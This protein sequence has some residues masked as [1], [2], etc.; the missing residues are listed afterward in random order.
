MNNESVAKRIA[1]QIENHLYLYG[2]F[3]PNNIENIVKKELEKEEIYINTEYNTFK[4]INL[5]IDEE[6]DLVAYSEQLQEYLEDY[7][8]E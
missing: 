3:A 8:M 4:A 5:R 2:K 1:S 6:G 7:S